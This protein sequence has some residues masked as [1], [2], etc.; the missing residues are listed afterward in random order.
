MIT[1]EKKPVYISIPFRGDALAELISRRLRREIGN[2]YH[3]ADLRLIFSCKPILS[4]QMKDR[5]PWDTTSFCIYQFVC[6]WGASYIG[7]TTRRLAD[8]IR[9]HHPKR[10]GNGFLKNGATA[11]ANHVAE[12][13]HSVDLIAS[14]RLIYTFGR[15][16]SMEIRVHPLSITQ[17]ITIRLNNPPLCAQK[18]FVRTLN[19]PWPSVANSMT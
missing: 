7:R 19:L 15:L 5:I 16:R 2:T 14:F 8:R 3:A 17:A 18:Q 11:I 10:L 6:S 4:L 1:V 13:N 9:E 12:T